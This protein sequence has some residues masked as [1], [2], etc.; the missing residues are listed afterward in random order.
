M[1]GTRHTLGS[2]ETGAR[3]P[4][5][6]TLSMRESNF[7]H[8]TVWLPLCVHIF[9]TMSSVHGRDETQMSSLDVV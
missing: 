5:L 4:P 1:R 3:R 7:T 2:Q 8:M 9:W 6:W